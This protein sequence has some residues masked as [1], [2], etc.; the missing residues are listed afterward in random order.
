[1]N[2]KKVTIVTVVC[3]AI[4]LLGGGTGIWFLEFQVL[5]P[6]VQERNALAAQLE[7]VKGKVRQNDQLRKDIAKLDD[8][9]KDEVKKIPSLDR[10]EYDAFANELDEIRRRAGVTVARGGWVQAQKPQ[11]VAGRPTPRPQPPAVHRVEYDL[12]VSGGFYQL[13]RYINLLE[14]KTRFVNVENFTITKSGEVTGAGAAAALRRDM[15]LIL[16]SYTY[17]PPPEAMEIEI[18]EQRKGRSTDIP[19]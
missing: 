4:I 19:D 12:A 9:L 7:E 17:R 14:Q 3:L 16:Y 1:M 8:L 2:E 15:K 10:T 18:E 5:E 6:K 13:L 11:P